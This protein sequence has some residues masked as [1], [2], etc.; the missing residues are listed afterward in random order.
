MARFIDLDEEDFEPP[1]ALHGNHHDRSDGAG[2]RKS[3]APIPKPPATGRGDDEDRNRDTRL[4]RSPVFQN[5]A[6]AAFGCYP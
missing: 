6:T 1:L 5:S 3:G 2:A 4:V